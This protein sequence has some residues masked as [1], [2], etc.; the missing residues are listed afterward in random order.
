VSP[1]EEP[2]EH[3]SADRGSY[4]ANGDLDRFEGQASNEIRSGDEQ[5]SG[6][7]GRQQ[8]VAV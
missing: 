4:Q 6:G 1:R 7:D 8:Q 2:Q 5:R 3:R